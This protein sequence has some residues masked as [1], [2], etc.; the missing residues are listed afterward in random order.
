MPPESLRHMVQSARR[1][2]TVML[3]LIPGDMDLILV[4][5]GLVAAR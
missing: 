1:D 5:R 3:S 4:E 2:A